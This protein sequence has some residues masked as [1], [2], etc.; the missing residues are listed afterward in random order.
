MLK[1]LIVIWIAVLILISYLVFFSGP[2]FGGLGPIELPSYY[3]WLL[4]IY[5]LAIGIGIY[6]AYSGTKQKIS[7]SLGLLVLSL[8]CLLFA[9]LD[10]IMFIPTFFIPSSS[11]SFD[12]LI[13][14]SQSKLQEIFQVTHNNFAIWPSTYVLEKGCRVTLAAGIKN[15]GIDGMAHSFVI[16]ILPSSDEERTWASWD[17]SSSVIQINGTAYK[18]ISIKAPIDAKPGQYS[19]KIIACKDISYQGCTIQTANWG[20]PQD[21]QITIRDSEI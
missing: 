6:L 5:F 10:I 11:C 19:F 21:L 3:P 7:F 1:L 12:D 13:W 9:L 4:A 17:N 16:N 14:I 15:D 2:V 18:S 20:E 8:L